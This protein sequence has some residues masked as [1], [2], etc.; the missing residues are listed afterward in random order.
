MVSRIQDQLGQH[1]TP[2]GK[3]HAANTH[4]ITTRYKPLQFYTQNTKD[5]LSS[6]F[7]FLNFYIFFFISFYQLCITL[8]RPAAKLKNMMMM[9][10]IMMTKTLP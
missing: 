2:T 6:F 8:I 4:M 1:R 5:L 3:D 9:M 7:Y 10:I